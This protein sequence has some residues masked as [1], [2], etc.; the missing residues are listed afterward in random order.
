MKIYSLLALGLVSTT[1][2]FGQ[3]KVKGYILQPGRDTIWGMVAIPIVKEEL[4]LGSL[5]KNI[6][7]SEGSG[8]S[9]KLKPKDIQ[10]FGI[11]DDEI[12]R[13]YATVSKE[14]E[15]IF[16]RRLIDGPIQLLEEKKDTLLLGYAALNGYKYDLTTKNYTKRTQKSIYYIQKKS[17]PLLRIDVD[18]ETTQIIKKDIPK[19]IAL[20]PGAT[21]TEGLLVSDLASTI[22]EYNSKQ[23][24]DKK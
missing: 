22:E 4:D 18:L 9:K 11:I 12:T 5:S 7:F 19:I 17:E 16:L 2:L 3:Y 20:F 14:G 1:I 21:K 6:S 10:G 8:R 13:D 15:L 23:N 24:S